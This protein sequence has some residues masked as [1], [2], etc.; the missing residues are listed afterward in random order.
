MKEVMNVQMTRDQRYY[1]ARLMPALYRRGITWED[2]RALVR[3]PDLLDALYEAIQ[4]I[5]KHRNSEP[6]RMSIVFNDVDIRELGLST[7]V[8]N[9]LLQYDITSLGVLALQT[10][11]Q[12][13]GLP[14]F[15]SMRM[16]E[17]QAVLEAH[18]LAYRDFHV[19][20]ASQKADRYAVQSH[21]VREFLATGFES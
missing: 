13:W 18:G 9:T 17:L 4:V 16:A 6:K 1:G 3:R 7:Q 2:V 12:V 21:F 14:Q 20:S 8:R 15:G 5:L 19:E 10:H 11:D